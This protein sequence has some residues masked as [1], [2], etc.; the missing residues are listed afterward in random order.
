M[1]FGVMTLHSFN[2]GQVQRNLVEICWQPLTKLD[3]VI[4]HNFMFY[5]VGSGRDF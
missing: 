5:G 1:V 3:S 2:G 4:A